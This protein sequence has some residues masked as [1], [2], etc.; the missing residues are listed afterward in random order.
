MLLLLLLLGMRVYLHMHATCASTRTRTCTCT[1]TSTCTCACVQVCELTELADEWEATQGA[2]T[3]SAPLKPSGAFGFTSGRQMQWNALERCPH[4]LDSHTS[5]SRDPHDP[6][7][8]A[9]LHDEGKFDA[10]VRP[11][12]TRLKLVHAEAPSGPDAQC[13]PAA[14]APTADAA[15]TV[16]GDLKRIEVAPALPLARSSLVGLGFRMPQVHQDS[17]LSA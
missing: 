5:P 4:A 2:A 10:F 3:A 9:P 14:S 16:C 6:Q 11:R 15:G 12:P 1:S 13:H 17:L 8:R 7:P